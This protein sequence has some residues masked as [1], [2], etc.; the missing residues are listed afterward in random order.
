MREVDGARAALVADRTLRVRRQR[1][2]RSVTPVGF[3]PAA[4]VV[5]VTAGHCSPLL[6]GAHDAPLIWIPY[7]YYTVEE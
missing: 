6:P 7:Y 5:A 2:R 1:R 4:E 3:D